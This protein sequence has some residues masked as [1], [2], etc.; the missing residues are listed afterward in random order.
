MVL[1]PVLFPMQCIV[2]NSIIQT[3]IIVYKSMK[4]T[5]GILVLHFLHLHQL[6]FEQPTIIIYVHC[7]LLNEPAGTTLTLCLAEENLP[8]PNNLFP[9]LIY[10]FLF[11]FLSLAPHFL[12]YV[13]SKSSADKFI[14]SSI[15]QHSHLLLIFVVFFICRNMENMLDRKE[16]F[17]WLSRVLLEIWHQY[18]MTPVML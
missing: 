12:R 15:K 17:G 18:W 5:F 14:S 7:G 8:M 13:L 1:C 3:K 4:T 2:V 16:T 6:I 11:Q 9:E 10:Y